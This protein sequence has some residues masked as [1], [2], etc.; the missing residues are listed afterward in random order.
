MKNRITY[1]LG[2]T[3]LASLSAG[4]LMLAAC[5]EETFT[6]EIGSMPDEDAI[7]G[8][9]AE[10]YRPSSMNGIIRLIEEDVTDQLR[11][12]L[13]QAAPE[14]V[15]VTVAPDAELCEA[16]NK[17]HGTDF[18]LFPVENVSFGSGNGAVAV[19]AGKK[20]S[21]D[22]TVTFKREGVEKGR[23]LLPVRATVAGETV[24]A[25]DQQQVHFYRLL[26][27]EPTEATELAVYPFKM[28]GYVNTDEMN[29]LIGNG[30]LC[31]VTDMIE[32][33]MV[34]QTCFDIEILRTASIGFD[35]ALQHPMLKLNP[36]LQYILE[37]REQ[38]IVPLQKNGHQ[39]LF[40]ITGSSD[41][42]GFRNLT[43]EYIADFVYQVEKVVTGYR[44]DGVNFFDIESVYDKEG[45]PAI[46][47]TSYAKLIKATKEALG[48]EKLVTIACDAASSEELSVAQD[49]IEA[50]QYL[51]MAWS[52]IFDEVVDAY[53]ENGKLKPIAGL[54][55]SQYGGV[56]LKTNNTT[57][58]E[59][60]KA[61]LTPQ[62]TALYR[63]SNCGKLFVFWDMPTTSAG[64]EQGPVDTF[65][66]VAE[67][68]IDWD[69][70]YD[71]LYF[72][73]YSWQ[74]RIV[75]GYGRFK[76]DW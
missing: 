7:T 57:K 18:A 72:Y 2:R 50:G 17:E 8:V 20:E 67:A 29:P 37:N 27:I 60:L 33:N 48:A 53:T 69:M 56:M 64:Y 63:E 38:Y 42:L 44:L 35:K 76:K 45:M 39:V 34:E 12:R 16:Y 30:F 13:S 65:N 71:D 52:G 11:I 28:V 21:A 40:C 9:S 58:Q 3:I 36:D 15:N 54:T 14:A 68:L 25:P 70:I 74:D 4:A 32:F 5:S 26:V 62:I 75:H 73:M 43:D 66:M 24:S 51:D 59:E 55:Q 41:G 19:E 22:L 23:Y 49:G 47:P 31:E 10:L 1:Q 6:R 61:I 46:D